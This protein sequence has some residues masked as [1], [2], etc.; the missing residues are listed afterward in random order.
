MLTGDE[1]NE[2]ARAQPLMNV[3]AGVLVVEQLRGT[4]RAFIMMAFDFI[5]PGLL[6]KSE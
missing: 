5:C 6:F 2:P 4:D 3:G 1:A